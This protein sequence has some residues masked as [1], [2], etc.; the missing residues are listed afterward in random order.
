[1]A[2]LISF[3][4]ACYGAGTPQLD[5]FAF[6]ASKAR[7]DIAPHPFLARLPQR[8]LGHPAGGALAAIGH[9]ERAWGCSFTWPGAGRQIQGFQE[10]LEGLLGGGTVGWAMDNFNRRYAE[11]SSDLTGILEDIQFG[12]EA[13]P[14]ELGG[15]WTANNDARGYAVLGDPAVRLAV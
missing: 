4:F 5:D 11:L 2:G 1:V 14:Q 8:L 12:Q 15:L 9:V 6:Q 3:H 10:T 13:D 7:V